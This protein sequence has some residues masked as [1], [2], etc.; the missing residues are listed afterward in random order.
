[1]DTSQDCMACLLLLMMMM[2]MLLMHETT[3]PAAGM[4]KR[5]GQT[6]PKPIFCLCE[7]ATAPTCHNKHMLCLAMLLP[8]VCAPRPRVV[9]QQHTK[10]PAAR[11]QHSKENELDPGVGVSRG[12]STAPCHTAMLSSASA[13]RAVAS[14]V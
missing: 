3:P 6:G 4:D 8:S 14:V 1:M 13:R 10:S 11:E 5:A 9:S 2:K 12:L 7:L